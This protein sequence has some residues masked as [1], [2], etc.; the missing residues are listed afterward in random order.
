MTGDWGRAEDVVQT[1]L[2]HVWP[3]WSRIRRAD[4]PDVYVRAVLVRTAL[5][6]NRRRWNR[7]APTALH[8]IPS[9]SVESDPHCVERLDLL[10]AVRRLPP[11]QCAVITLRFF[12]DRS[13]R[14]TA[15][16]MRCAT[17]T[18]KSQT[19]KALAALRRDA[20]L[21]IDTK[22]EQWP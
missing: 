6:S 5:A 10:V 4:A 19:A 20:A 15:Q 1:T 16:I 14:E 3:R 7:E 11:K 21:V 8:S 22:D 9:I 18:V 17:G 12:E 13:E 2:M